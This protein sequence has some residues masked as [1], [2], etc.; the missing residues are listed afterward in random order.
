MKNLYY[1]ILLA[2]IFFSC[3]KKSSDV[4]IDEDLQLHM[5]AGEF[6]DNW[7]QAAADADFDEY[8]NVIA[9]DGVYV[10][11]DK[12][13]VW[14]KEEFAE[15]SKPFFDKGRAWD[16]EAIER[17]MYVG[18]DENYIWFN[19]ILDTWMGVCRGSGVIELTNNED[20]PFLIQHYVLSLTVPNERIQQ[21]IKAIENE[22]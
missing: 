4:I 16:F 11:T 5:D 7:H 1:S 13:E 15:F 9:S 22:D 8:F 19:E 17:N 12:S 2:F 18:K 20:E 14:N 21:V 10:G 6:L 3:S